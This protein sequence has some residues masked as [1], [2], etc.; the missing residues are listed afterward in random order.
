MPVLCVAGGIALLLA[1]APRA[2]GAEP[3][4][5]RV[6]LDS[7][8]EVHAPPGF[9][10]EGWKTTREI[11]RRT[12]ERWFPGLGLRGAVEDGTPRQLAG[13]LAALPGPKV[14]G[15]SVVYVAT[16][17]SPD[18]A[19]VFAGGERRAWG[20]VL[21]GAGV[22]EHPSRIVILDACYATRARVAPGWRRLAPLALFASGPNEVTCEL[23]LSAK[24]PVDFRRHHPEAWRWTQENLPADWDGKVSFLGLAW[25]EAFLKTP[26][27]PASPSDWRGFFAECERWAGAFRDQVD[28]RWA[29]RISW[30]GPAASGNSP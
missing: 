2:G 18:G 12:L 23:D 13:F 10:L 4:P 8:V 26:S 7:F 24:R 14:A 17:Q 5:T 15:T 1:I 9:P 25:L 30:S 16:R 21:G 28:R 3:S 11:V 29:S 27:P 6:C 22:T 19:F 20:E